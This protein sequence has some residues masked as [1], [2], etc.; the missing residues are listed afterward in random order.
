MT[1]ASRRRAFEG[2]IYAMQIGDT[3][4]NANKHVTALALT[5]ACVAYA[6]G[7]SEQALPAGFDPSQVVM[8]LERGRCH[9]SCPE[10]SV[11]IRGDGSVTYE[12]KSSVLVEGKLDWTIPHADVVALIDEIQKAGYFEL[13]DEYSDGSFDG[14]HC[15]SLF[16]IAN[17]TKSVSDRGGSSC[18]PNAPT[19]KCVPDRV[20]A[21][22]DAIDRHS[23]AIGLTQGNDRTIALLEQARFDFHATAAANALLFALEEMNTGLA[24]ELLSRG[25]PMNGGGLDF[26]S[27]RE[28]CILLQSCSCQ[29]PAMSNSRG[30]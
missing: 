10:Y 7:S 8:R 24:R 21:I 29:P 6:S 14:P 1:Q 25:A 3:M 18:K 26:S 5:A 19:D 22:H 4:R 20:R 15:E 11:E 23:G 12:G 9:G 30:R 13:K 28:N 2:I 17:K 16:T 27:L